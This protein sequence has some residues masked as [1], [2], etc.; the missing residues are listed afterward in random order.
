[1]V[2]SWIPNPRPTVRFCYLLL[3][4]VVSDAPEQRNSHIDH[5]PDGTAGVL[6][7][8]KTRFDSVMVYLCKT[9]GSV[10]AL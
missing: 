3:R 8:S 4:E 10:F 2:T 5:E 9:P 7:T 1:V 6:H